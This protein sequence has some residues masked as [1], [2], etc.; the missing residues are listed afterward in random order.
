MKSGNLGNV[1]LDVDRVQS[2]VGE[3]PDA[4][5][6]IENT[7]IYRGF[8]CQRDQVASVFLLVACIG[9]ECGL[10]TDAY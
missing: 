10:E 6:R 7:R 3:L 2:F 5:Y 9:I 4:V 1:R 8:A